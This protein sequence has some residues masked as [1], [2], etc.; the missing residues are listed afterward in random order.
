MEFKYNV[1]L[2]YHPNMVFDQNP[3]NRLT[4]RKEGYYLTKSVTPVPLPTP[5]CIT[6]VSYCFGMED[7]LFW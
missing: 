6:L 1:K 4:K 5:H 7:K 2:G 3:K